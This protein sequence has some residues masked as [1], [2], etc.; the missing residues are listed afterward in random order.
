MFLPLK[1]AAFLSQVGSGICCDSTTTRH[2]PSTAIF[3]PQI[4]ASPRTPPG[5]LTPLT[6]AAS[7]ASHGATEHAIITRAHQGQVDLWLAVADMG[8]G[9]WNAPYASYTQL[10]WR[11]IFS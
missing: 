5:A 7:A 8:G 11:E 9:G 1:T 6:H 4:A 2:L 3:Q 10:K